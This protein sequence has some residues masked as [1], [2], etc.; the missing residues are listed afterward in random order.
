[1]AGTAAPQLLGSAGPQSLSIA[2]VSLNQTQAAY[3]LTQLMPLHSVPPTSFS[4]SR[5]GHL[6]A[7]LGLPHMLGSQPRSSTLLCPRQVLPDSTTWSEGQERKGPVP[8]S[9]EPPV[10]SAGHWTISQM[11]PNQLLPPTKSIWGSC[12]SFVYIMKGE[13]IPTAQDSHV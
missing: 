7:H 6:G 9:S 2:P 5:K 11:R 4:I 10:T 12:C 8:L 13:Q 1:M 3:L